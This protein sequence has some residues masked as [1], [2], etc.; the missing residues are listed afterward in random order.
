[1]SNPLWSAFK[2]TDRA[3]SRLYLDLIRE[4]NALIAFFFHGLWYDKSTAALN[5]VVPYNMITV[6]DFRQF[7]EYF[8]EQNY[9]F[10]SPEDILNGLDP[11]RKFVLTT[12]D[13]GYSNNQLALP[14]LKEF[15]I[16][17]TFFISTRPVK[18]NRS[19]WW[20]VLYRQRIKRGSTLDAID[21]ELESYKSSTHLQIERQISDLFGPKAFEP[22]GEIDRPLTP[23]ELQRLA[24][25]K[26]VF[27]GNH[28]QDHAILTNYDTATIQE[29]L[30][31]SQK[32]L[33]L[34]TGRAPM[35]L[36]YPNGRYNETV[37]RIAQAVGLKIGLTTSHRKNYLP[38]TSSSQRLLQLGRFHLS[39]EAD[40]VDR[41][42][43]IRSDIL[44]YPKL[45]E[46]LKKGRD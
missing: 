32:D 20:D 14:V 40:L 36:A 13:D 15:Q 34:L 45:K 31:E 39:S 5:V 1:M 43:F 21:R 23:A 12:F 24:A 9:I 11:H 10:V 8:L 7:V 18:E 16:P 27:I 33:D 19:F 44:V 26:Y 46:L 25:E 17:A 3:I 30:V 41:C 2:E 42:K 37:L 38:L 29:Q 4:R 28:T 35:S 6:Q 22:L